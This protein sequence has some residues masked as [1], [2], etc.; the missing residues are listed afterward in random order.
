VAQYFEGTSRISASDLAA[1]TGLKKGDRLSPEKLNAV[2]RT[3]LEK[4]AKSM[5]GQ[6]PP[7]KCRMQITIEGN[8]TLT[9]ILGEPE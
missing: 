4:C 3:I 9:W 5:P 1:A 7:L 8:V 6:V 2:R